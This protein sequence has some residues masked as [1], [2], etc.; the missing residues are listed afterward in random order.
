VDELKTW[1][2]RKKKALLKSPLH[3]PL[4]LVSHSRSTV[5]CDFLIFLKKYIWCNKTIES[6]VTGC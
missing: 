2:P 4:D 1:W 6:G 5:A 3:G